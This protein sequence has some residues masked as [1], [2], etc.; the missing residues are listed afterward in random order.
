MGIQTEW[1]EVMKGFILLSSIFIAKFM[2]LNSTNQPFNIF[3]KRK[4]V[5]SYGRE[6]T[7]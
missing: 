3:K 1:I 5:W 6:K 7:V 4:A 2:N